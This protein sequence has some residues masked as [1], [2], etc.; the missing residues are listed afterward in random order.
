ML[1][2]EISRRYPMA[3]LY[4]IRNGGEYFIPSSDAS[5][6]SDADK[7]KDETLLNGL[8]ALGDRVSEFL[9]CFVIYGFDVHGRPVKLSSR[10]SYMERTAIN[11]LIMDDLER[12][13]REKWS[14][15][16]VIVDDDDDEDFED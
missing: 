3:G 7:K 16:D 5:P 10:G 8:S 9:N 12:E 13:E 2:P 11:G 6:K 1:G 4:V 15:T 14:F